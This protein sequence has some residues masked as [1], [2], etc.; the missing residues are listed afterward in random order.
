MSRLALSDLRAR[1]VDE[2]RSLPLDVE[3]ALRSDPRAGARAILAAVARLRHDR[4]AEG[5]RLRKICRYE[6]ALL[7]LAEML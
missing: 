7:R 2:R 4:R 5:Q 6:D 1:Y 3:A